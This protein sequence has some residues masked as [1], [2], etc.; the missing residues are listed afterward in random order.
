LIVADPQLAYSR[1]DPLLT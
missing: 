1:R